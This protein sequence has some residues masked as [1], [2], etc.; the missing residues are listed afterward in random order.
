MRAD[1]RLALL[2]RLR[3]ADWIEMPEREF[4]T[5]I[6]RLEKDP[7]FQKLFFGETEHRSAIRRQRWP[8]G[9]LSGSFYE[10]NES[11]VAG[12][13]RVK[14]EEILG[15]KG[16]VLGLIRKMGREAFERYFVHADEPLTLAEIGKRT[17]LAEED[18]RAIH[19]VL[20]EIGAQEEF[21]GPLKSESGR[22]YACLA[23][24]TLEDGAAPSFEF[25]TPHWAR[26][27]YQVRYD[28]LEDWKRQSLSPDERRKLPR[29]LK[30]IETLNLRQNTLYRILESVSGLQADFL[31]CGD[32]ARRRPIS[33]RQL[34]HRLSLAP[35]TVSRALSGRSVR[36]PWGQEMPLI[37]LV[38]GRRRVVKELV[39]RW[40]EA[41]VKATDA[42]LAGRLKEEHAIRVSR[43]TVNAVRHS[44]R[45]S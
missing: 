42:E 26:G 28:L 23:R 31:G 20:L 29:L 5:E 32:T 6:A 3:M 16:K 37:E 35:S 8:R 25:L 21:Q 9:A 36:M 22:A 45:R 14:V 4:A 11:V 2:G 30:R 19:E 12:G 27:L 10:V 24:L 40:L 44:L 43:R 38:P 15:E 7:L 39:G 33:L 1:Q 18:V 13:E 41:G 17:G 34:A